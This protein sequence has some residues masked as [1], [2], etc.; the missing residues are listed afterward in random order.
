MQKSLRVI[1]LDDEEHAL[2]NLAN[3]IM[4][5]DPTVEV[6]AKFMDPFE[7]INY[8]KKHPIDLFFLDIAMP[9]LN[10]FEVLEKIGKIIPFKTVFVTAY[11]EYA[12]QA[13]KQNVFDYI[14]KPIDLDQL[15]ECLFE[16]KI[17][18]LNPVERPENKLVIKTTDKIHFV[19]PEDIIY[20]ESEN[21][22]TELNLISGDVIV[23][24]KSISYFNQ[25]LCAFTFN[26]CHNSFIV[27]RKFISQYDKKKKALVLHDGTFIP[28][29]RGRKEE[30]LD[31]LLMD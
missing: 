24:T 9:V 31:W 8:A 19:T 28:V 7:A 10:G 6:C 21:T 4:T 15:K 22:Y 3:A 30:M 14:L 12:I 23:T 13:I 29:S 25:N 5:V 11:S 26:R 2:E 1:L 16:T 17:N 27:Q 18:Q 20:I